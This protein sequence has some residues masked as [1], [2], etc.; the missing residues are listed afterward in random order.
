MGATLA[1]VLPR[2]DAAFWTAA[3]L[4]FS[5]AVSLHLILPHRTEPGH[6]TPLP[7]WTK[8]PVVAMVILTIVL[9]K[10]V[11]HGFMP[12][13]PMVGV[14]AVYEARHSLWTICRQVPAILTAFVP[15]MV[16]VRLTQATIGLGRGLLVGW[17]VLLCILVPLM[18]KMWFARQSGIEQPEDAAR[19]GA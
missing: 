1:R 15:M 4:V 19:P 13:F 8:L 14:I 3:A 9:L 12:L 18:W 6:R 16:T 11:L 17:C 10:N 7:L 2:T 5:I